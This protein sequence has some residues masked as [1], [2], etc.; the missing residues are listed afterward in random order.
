MPTAPTKAAGLADGSSSA[1]PWPRRSEHPDPA[2]RMTFYLGIPPS[3][4][5]R[6][7][8]PTCVSV[9]ALLRC[10]DRLPRAKAPYLLDSGAYTMLRDHGGW[11][12][13]VEEYAATVYR[14]IDGLGHPPTAVAIPDWMCEPWIIHGGLHRGHH[15]VGTDLD[16]PIH[17][18]LTTGAYVHLN[19]EHTGVPW[20]P[21][22]QGH[23]LHDY[24]DH[25]HQYA[26]AGVDLTRAPLVGLGSVCA[27][28]GTA[29]IAAI[30]AAV[31][32]AG[33]DR[34]HGFGV[35]TTG[36]HLYGPHL[37]SVDSYAWSKG[38][39]LRLPDCTH[40]GPCNNCIRYA[41][42]WREHVLDALRHPHQTS[43]PLDF[44]NPTNPN[45][46]DTKHTTDTPR[47]RKA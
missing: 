29:E 14:L 47:D 45:V 35:K 33:I 32:A 39:R 31:R 25:I 41:L 26:R 13:F 21:I 36:L 9:S 40:P 37:R 23:R 34:L 42:A 27:R 3:A 17:Q 19:N 46:A 2:R 43:L 1:T 20:M 22:L 12:M 6:V 28:Q 30:V 8:V 15:Y 18:A 11:T 4:M 44:R 16:V 24:L 10:G 5:P 7:D 38:A